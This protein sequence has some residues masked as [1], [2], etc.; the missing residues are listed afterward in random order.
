MSGA[1][2]R[3]ELDET[4]VGVSYNA[5]VTESGSALKQMAA[6]RL[7]AHRN[8]RAAVQAREA[9]LEA[10]VQARRHDSRQGVSR[11]R[12]AVAA[13]YEH[14]P[15]YREF[16]AAESERALQQARA[17]A[18]IAARNAQAIAEAQA[19]LI[20]ELEQWEK[21]LPGPREVKAAE[22][23]RVTE[24]ANVDLLWEADAPRITEVV[25]EAFVV[26]EASR[27]SLRVQMYDDL[28]TVARGA[29]Q[30]PSAQAALARRMAHAAE[31]VEMEGE[32]EELEQEIAFRLSPGFEDH[33]LEMTAI[34]ANLIEFPRQLVASRK[35]RPR[36]AEG[37]LREESEPEPQLRI[38][39]VEPEQISVEPEVMEAS[40][41]AAWQSLELDAAVDAIASPI[42]QAQMAAMRPLTASIERRL[43][44]LAVDGCC[45]AAA[46]IG[47]ATVVVMV[48]GHAL[49]GFPLKGLGAGFAATMLA[50]FVVYELLFFTFAD[51]TPGMRYARIGLC[52]FGDDN[53][54]RR[55][56][57][58]RVAAKLLAASPLGIG[59]LWAWMDE[60]KLGW[61]DRMSRMYQRSY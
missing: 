25:S 10:T 47:F 56:M 19:K 3:T 38:F 43:M 28:G 42:A 8:R 40:G 29:E 35:A 49:Q 7:A 39:E 2:Q 31:H 24:A 9:E 5:T 53:P 54:T 59:L 4:M 34:P 18:E 41:A 22:P 16:L 27:A 23:L 14:S 33:T 37:P 45:V 32:L 1:A 36:L 30:A 15:S 57:R 50:M 17:E 13:R 11:I 26:S 48:A 21:P 61:H 6:E 55:A 60:D 58:M 12:D 52:T 51:G 46:S 44:A 20:Q